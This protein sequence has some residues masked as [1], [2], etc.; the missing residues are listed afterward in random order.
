M[1]TKD[2][3]S[4]LKGDNLEMPTL[5][6]R[7][8]KPTEKGIEWQ[9]EQKRSKFRAAMTSW[10]KQAVKIENLL[11]ET[12]DISLIKH[13]RGALEQNMIEVSSS[14]EQLNDLFRSADMDESEYSN[15]EGVEK[16]H[17]LIA[18]KIADA[19]KD[20]E[21]EKNEVR[22]YRSRSSQN[23]ISSQ[24]SAASKRL[25][26]A[27]EAAAMRT[28]LKY[29][30][31]EAQIEKV[32]A[33][34]G[35][36]IAE[37]KLAAINQLEGEESDHQDIDK[38]LPEQQDI[39][40]YIQSY[41]ETHSVSEQAPKVTVPDNGGGFI[42]ESSPIDKVR[43]QVALNPSAGEYVPGQRPQNTWIY[44]PI[45]SGN[46]NAGEPP[47]RDYGQNVSQQQIHEL[48]RSF[49]EQVSLSR[50][51]VPEP[52]TFNGD[53]LKFPG[54]KSSFDTLIDQKGI[55]SNE[56]IHYLKRYLTGAA[57][58]AIEG[59]FLLSTDDAYVEARML[60]EQRYGDPFVIANA[61]RDKLEE[62]PK[63][64]PKDGLALRKF[65]DFLK[66]CEKAMETT[67]SLSIL[68]D[69][70]ENRKLLTK[71]P[72]WLVA[73]WAR[74]AADWKERGRT[75]PPFKEFTRFM[76]KESNIACDPITSI[77]ALK[78]NDRNTSDKNSH[79]VGQFRQARAL[80]TDV[81][82]KRESTNN[83]QK[84]IKCVLCSKGHDIDDCKIFLSKSLED[85]KNYCMIKGLCFR[86][87]IRGHLA[88]ECP[89]R[90][91]C[92]TC[93]GRHPTSL[94]MGKR[95]TN[96]RMEASNS[97]AEGSAK[98][99][100]KPETAA[101]A[102]C[103]RIRTTHL[104]D[105]DE[106]GKSSMIVPV[107]VSHVEQPEREIMVYALL[108]TQSDTTFILEDTCDSLCVKGH[109]T[110]LWLST[111]LAEDQLIESRRVEGLVVRGHDS[112]LKVP[113]PATYT[114][115][116]VPA[117]R[118][119]I[120]T[121]EMTQNWPHLR[122]I[123]KK[124]M[125]LNDCKVA[126]L[127]G[128]DCSRA[129]V[130]REVI[131]PSGNGPYAE[132]TDLGWG[133]VGIIDPNQVEVDMHDPIGVSHRILTYNIPAQLSRSDVR[134]DSLGAKDVSNQI[135]VSLKTAVKEIITPLEVNRMME[136]DFNERNTGKDDYSQHDL[137][138]LRTMKEG[139]HLSDDGHYQMPLP[140]KLKDPNLPNNRVMAM[141]RLRQLEKNFKR[142]EK[143]QKDYIAFMNEVIDKGYAEKVPNEDLARDD[144]GVY[145]IPHHGVYHPKKPDKIRVVFDCSA[146]YKGES[147]ND[148]L[149]RGPDLTNTL[150][151]VLSRFR[152]EP[153][154]FMCD[155]EQMFY[156][157]KVNQEHRDFLRFLWWKDGNHKDEV[158]EYRMNVHLFGAASSPGCAN[159]GLK[160][161]ANDNEKE[162]GEKAADFIRNNFYVDD[163]LKSVAT[164]SEAID[165]IA[166]SKDICAK[167]GLRLHKIVSNSRE[168]M[169]TV[170]SEDMA[171]GLKELDFNIDALPIERALGVQWCIESDTFQFRIT[172]KDQPLTRRGILSTVCSVFDPLG[173]IA[174]VVIVGK[175]ILQE[176]CRCQADWDS[177]LPDE[178][179]PRWEK[180]RSELIKL[181]SVKL[182][183]CFKPEDFGKVKL[184][185][186]HHFSDASTVGYGQGSYL[187]LINE[188]DEVHC[189]LVMGKA[190]VTPLKTVTI[191]RLELT[192]ALLSV[193]VSS[194]LKD[195]LE[196]HIDNE[197]FWSDSKV[198]LGY[199]ANA[200]KRFHV[201]V[202]NRVQQIRDQTDPSQWK[203]VRSGEN[204][205]DKAS[206]GVNADELENNCMWFKGPAF[207]WERDIPQMDQD[208]DRSVSLTDPE[209][210]RV[211]VLSTKANENT[212][213][214]D[215]K[216]LEYFS[217]WL[218][219]KRA[220]AACLRFKT[221]LLNKIRNKTSHMKLRRKDK[222]DYAPMQVE[223]MQGAE[224]EIIKLTQ[225][226]AFG[227]EIKILESL[228]VNE[229]NLDRHVATERKMAMKGTSQLYRLD[230]FLDENGIVRVG[231]RIRNSL[232]SSE[233]KHPVILPR[234]HH[235]TEMVVQHFH[236]KTGHG[237]RGMT[238]NE[239]RA[240][241]FW[242]IGCSGAVSKC[243]STCVKCRKLRSPVQ[244]Q[245]MA[246][247]PA[248]RLEQVP[249]F[250][251]CG[252]DFFGPWYTKEGRKGLKRYGCLFTCMSKRAVHIETANSLETDSFINAL[253]RF[254]SIR[255][256]MRQLRCD[257]G[258]N[259]IGASRELQTEMNQMNHTRVKEFLL[260][261][262]CDYFEFKMN[263]PSASHMGGVWERQI[264]TI[265]K[266][267][268]SLM[269]QAGPQLNDESLRTLMC[270]AAAIVNSRPLS[271]DNLNDPTSLAPLTPNH[272]LTMKSR[273]ILPPPGKFQEADLYCR[274]QWR[275]VQHLTNEFWT[276]WKL[277][278][279]NDL[280]SRSKWSH[281]RREMKTGD[282]V[283]V[284]DDN[285]PRN[286]WLLAR[287]DETYPS[288]DGH[289]RKV[290][291][292]IANPTLDSKG[293]PTKPTS[294]LDR[295]IHK[296]VLL[297]EQ[298][299]EDGV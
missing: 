262:Q 248:D 98:D 4:D 136:L 88:A 247:L 238:T 222:Q 2:D 204:P 179:R 240:N 165:V 172:L 117:N 221:K 59:Y 297:V 130:P 119:H 242:V 18:R 177:P 265:R 36:E 283:I 279:L 6:V 55:P 288:K 64:P 76:V 131:P 210:K 89:E 296:L 269:D 171:K 154:A 15:Y 215:L 94:H 79:K 132:R 278:Y 229:S 108:D 106:A 280:Q 46:V 62:W 116:I 292:A 295:P 114:R 244:G 21:M 86:C 146:K 180:W 102:T 299:D 260:K 140:F 212:K 54:W 25:D 134:D 14:Y 67:G 163:G 241:G 33:M 227:P 39:K 161:T 187:R 125:P 115:N 277:E 81:S 9:V 28:R 38:I 91:T 289:V 219:A 191:P 257:Q 181:K 237:G 174:P 77:Q 234:K 122:N 200:S 129:L 213:G 73:R 273:V 202:A 127:I 203:H 104:C 258:T 153:V 188:Q 37:A 167:G 185:E 166:R 13:Q 293:K 254:L 223:D 8:R 47:N 236:K 252:V 3:Q 100:S 173:F 208:P 41:L 7:D 48:T 195:Q 264:R 61:F 231:G 259:F 266:V 107:W 82:E 218:H 230:P 189:S 255:G 144:G 101:K 286:Q 270:E 65:S 141:H 214:F 157:F 45:T 268:A 250:T 298:R 245:K 29:I 93:K 1:A 42:S 197:V 68:D 168:V 205:A 96:D 151:G 10:R 243:I 164:E 74:V 35:L 78:G 103:S 232:Y 72:D 159:Y 126:L 198:A 290:K 284:K 60:L 183:R 291:L 118:A 123:G 99:D 233:L 138:F 170:P 239:I 70:R 110:K 192:A 143:Y 71:L 285:L 51:P 16:D 92:K 120:P 216:R 31:I 184:A 27:T 139:I 137:K 11:S 220:I 206:R 69:S 271:V 217:D 124:L 196:Y 90:K 58:E 158:V 44:S 148:H 49:A 53:P 128:Y 26:A 23:S 190:R 113:L 12:Q 20:I 209:V 17:Y 5:G 56:R 121:P 176:M 135:H 63:I 97:K 87:L 275:R 84:E 95:K 133:I 263:P 199:I 228:K 224:M 32:Q 276:R 261:E 150:V 201:F 112:S 152:Q 40:Q 52:T 226:E 149:L 256:P 235:V 85:R 272:L 105:T 186:L 169:E 182:Q 175:Q 194:L 267:L 66:Q 249:P 50:L 287:V 43:T 251:Y 19:I 75:F 80:A 225:R 145:Y 156:Q 282:I 155:I 22:S 207:L 162:F 211:T 253:R 57:L 111:M 294:Y 274:K 193:R 160:Q 30:D 178:L 109:S 24:S 142:D 246:D 281:P 147:L 34:K 83:E